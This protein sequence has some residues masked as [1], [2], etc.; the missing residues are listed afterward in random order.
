MVTKGSPRQSLKGGLFGSF[1]LTH[2]LRAFD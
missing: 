2:S 1:G